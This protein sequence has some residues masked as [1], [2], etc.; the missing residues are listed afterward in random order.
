MAST[1]VARGA[2]KPW[3]DAKEKEDKVDKYW[4]KRDGKIA[5]KK[6][7]DM[8]KCG[9]KAMCDYCIPLEVRFVGSSGGVGCVTNLEGY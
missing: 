1:S 8:C 4:E 7:Q 2:S 3:E 6:G 9:P 5:R